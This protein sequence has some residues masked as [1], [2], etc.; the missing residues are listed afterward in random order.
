MS[1][2]FGKVRMRLNEVMKEKGISKSKLSFKAELQRT[3][4]NHYCDNKIVRVDFDILGRLCTALNCDITDL[5]EYI[6]PE[7]KKEH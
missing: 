1:E 6:P 2:E 4:L 5:L 3:Q 7:V